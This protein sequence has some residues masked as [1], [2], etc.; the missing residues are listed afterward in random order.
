MVIMNVAAVHI[1]LICPVTMP[2]CR[3]PVSLI[4]TVRI[5]FNYMLESRIPRDK[6]VILIALEK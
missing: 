2:P 5:L 6:I 1:D 3:G 4:G